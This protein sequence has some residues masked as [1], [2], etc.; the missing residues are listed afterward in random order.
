MFTK[1]KAGAVGYDIVV[2]S[3]DYA[4]IMMNENMLAKI[5]K[6]KISTYEIYIKEFLKSLKDLIKE[7]TMLFHTL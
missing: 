6:N 7:I 4:E 2:P 1:L 3:P 5:D